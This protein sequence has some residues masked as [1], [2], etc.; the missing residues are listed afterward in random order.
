MR[1]STL[2]KMK[3]PNRGWSV[4]GLP[5][6][7]EIP[8]GTEIEIVDTKTAASLVARGFMKEAGAQGEKKPAPR[9][10]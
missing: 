9:R 1:V 8:V 7:A 2:V 10:R 3:N 6:D 4:P 5:I